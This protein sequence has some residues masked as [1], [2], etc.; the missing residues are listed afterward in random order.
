MVAVGPL[1]ATDVVLEPATIGEHSPAGTA[2]GLLVAVPPSPAGPPQFELLDSAA[3]RFRLEGDVLF[4]NDPFLLDFETAPRPRVVIR[5]VQAGIPGEV[6]ALTVEVQDVPEGPFDDWRRAHFTDA[7]L[8]DP[9]VAGPYGNPDADDLNN[10]FEYSQGYPP[11]AGA[12][13]P[14][15]SLGDMALGD[16]VYLTFTY[17]RLKAEVDPDLSVEPWASEDFAHWTCG[18]AQFILVSRTPVSEELEEI[19]VRSTLPFD[20]VKR[21]FVRLRVLR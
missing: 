6:K 18:P 14:L 13:T 4:V 12:N 2:I 16:T 3:G 17:R 1:P 9:E 21:N 7:E 8:L 5:L 15:P 20:R 19:T 11:K 10:L